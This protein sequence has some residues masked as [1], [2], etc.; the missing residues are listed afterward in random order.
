[1]FLST[2]SL[3]PFHA[4]SRLVLARQL[5]QRHPIKHLPRNHG[6]ES[7]SLIRCSSSRVRTSA[8]DGSEG[9]RHS[10]VCMPCPIGASQLGDKRGSQSQSLPRTRRSSPAGQSCGSASSSAPSVRPRP[11]LQSQPTTSRETQHLS[12]HQALP[13]LPPFPQ[14]RALPSLAHALSSNNS[15]LTTSS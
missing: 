7:P 10:S 2:N 6:R 13:A 1:M 15:F 12:S 8:V 5:Q 11:R 9:G 4:N 14:L 3:L